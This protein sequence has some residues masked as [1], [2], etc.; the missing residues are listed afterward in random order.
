MAFFLARPNRSVHEDL[1]LMA[2]QAQG[3][4]P[5]A[6][7]S[8]KVK[9]RLHTLGAILG[10]FGVFVGIGT[11]R[12]RQANAAT[13]ETEQRLSGPWALQTVGGA[14]IGPHFTSDILLQRVTFENGKARGDTRL[15]ANTASGTTDMP[16]PDESAKS[17]TTSADG[18][19][20]DVAWEG[21]YTVLDSRRIELHIGKAVY[22]VEA[23]F[24][25]AFRSLEFDRDAILTLPGAT[26]Y[27]RE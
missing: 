11:T 7:R 17:A 26:S 4:N 20:L 2:G 27:R 10:A 6:P 16:F 23:H 15:R 14:A 9:K 22:R 3:E 21:S 1:Q 5:A 13:V 18:R 24:D 12:N 19:Y 25:S 8:P